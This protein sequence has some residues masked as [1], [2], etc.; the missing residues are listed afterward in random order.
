MSVHSEPMHIGTTPLR[1]RRVSPSPPPR[2][3]CRGPVVQR[4]VK[5]TNA[6]V[7]YP[8][9]TR[10]NYQDWAILMQVNLEAAGLW[11]AI[12]PEDDDD[13]EYRDD[14][15][16]L[17]AILR[18][19]LAEMLGTLG[20]KR[21]A[22]S[23][24]EALKTMRVGIER[25]REANAQQLPREFV[26]M[27]FKD[28]EGVEEF[29]NR[30]TG[31]ANNL[32]LLSD[33]ITDKEV[34]KKMMQVVPDY[35]EQVAISIETLLDL[36][37]ISIEEVT[38]RLRAVEQRCKPP[39]VYDNPGRLMLCEEDW[40][41]KLKLRDAEAGNSS[42]RRRR[43]TSLAQKVAAAHLTPSSNRPLRRPSPR[44]TP[45]AARTAASVDTG[46]RIAGASRSEAHVVEGE[47]E[48]EPML[49]MTSACLSHEPLPTTFAPASDFASAA[50]KPVRVVEAKVFAQQNEMKASGCR[51]AFTNLNPQ[52]HGSIK[53]GDGS[54]VAIE[55]SD[56]VVFQGR[57]GEHTPLT[58]VFFILR[59]T[60]NIIN[61]G[62]LDEGDCDV[63]I[64]KGLLRIH[65][66]WWLL[67]P[68][69]AQSIKS[70]SD[71]FSYRSDDTTWLWHERY[72][73]LHF[74]AIRKL[75]EKEMVC[76]LPH[77]DRAHQIC[78]DCVTTKLKRKP[79]PSQ[80]KHRSAGLLDLVHGDLC[81]PITP[82][83]P[84]R[85]VPKKWMIEA[86]TCGL[87][88]ACSQRHPAAP[89]PEKVEVETDGRSCSPGLNEFTSIE[90]ETWWLHG[91]RAAYTPTPHN[92][93]GLLRGGT[94]PWSP[95]Q[96]ACSRGELCQ[97]L[98][99]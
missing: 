82:S 38:G 79:F 17:A 7:H 26:A 20:R 44:R 36:N 50:T 74:D 57:H 65:E 90:F 22:L 46:P 66:M 81:G 97:L 93:T 68:A 35:L 73:H 31:L 25:V 18:Y 85:Y 71:T 64:N 29:T 51:G 84:G 15:L 19:V 30:I 43:R 4:V 49:L 45:T 40:A 23:A 80:A 72:R 1:R 2:H 55:G 39:P 70:P 3:G 86:V 94:N 98:G 11:H 13:V 75:G 95:W 28:G 34:V 78:S 91:I 62:Q 61:L 59:L 77:I 41:A 5:E 16:A 58:G 76:G 56:T 47:E 99:P 52:I 69:Y 24:W 96:E 10:T 14:R 92:K 42:G 87:Y 54:E 89:V 48:S 21:T 8:L 9:L 12:E 33:N 37:T 53:F 6:A 32:R 27:A 88:P 83:T 63:H 60:T 67:I